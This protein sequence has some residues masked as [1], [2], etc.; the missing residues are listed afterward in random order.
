M[1][2]KLFL[3]VFIGCLLGSAKSGAQ[4][5][6]FNVQISGKGSAVI[7]IPGFSCS[8]DVWSE[9]VKQLAVNHKCYVIT[10][11]GF[12]GVKPQANP[13]F[14]EWKDE[15]ANYIRN[16]K[17]EKPIVI[18]HSLGG[19]MALWLAA[20]YPQLI[21][22]VLVVDALPCLG[23]M[24][25]PAFKAQAKPDC[26]MF[27]NRFTSMNEQQFYDM[28][29]K[30]IA[31]LMADTAM[32]ETVINWSVKSDRN[33]LAQIFCQFTNTDLRET[34]ARVK[35]PSLVLLEPSFKGYDD[36][37]HQQYGKLKNVKL[38]YAA[39]GLHFIMYD[40]KAWYLNE[41]KQFLRRMSFLTPEIY[42]EYYPK[43]FRLCMGYVNDREL[44]GR[45]YAGNIYSRLAGFG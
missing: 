1:K 27:V 43:V 19:G 32:Q 21:G 9:T 44:A 15:V 16:N 5:S 12:A 25:N 7:L 36:A 13:Q 41:V 24:F 14:A 40:D 20:D 39:K 37:V 45:Y 8:G 26:S 23:A 11:P 2:K 33:T 3:L 29:K 34:L 4:Q 18:G 10:F 6:S 22:K 42:K 31:S 38:K 17:I 35:C 28:Q 30:N